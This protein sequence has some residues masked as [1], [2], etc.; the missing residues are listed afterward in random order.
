MHLVLDVV[1]W[2]VVVLDVVVLDVGGLLFR[3]ETFR[4]VSSGISPHHLSFNSPCIAATG[5]TC[6]K[7]TCL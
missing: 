4:N 2:D 6:G 7:Y 1:V 5:L 3:I